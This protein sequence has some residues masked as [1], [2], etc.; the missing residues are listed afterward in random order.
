MF[1]SRDITIN[2]LVLS[3]CESPTILT[4]LLTL[5]LVMVTMPP[6]PLAAERHHSAPDTPAPIHYTAF[7]VSSEVAVVPTIRSGLD[8]KTIMEPLKDA[9]LPSQV[10]FLL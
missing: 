8:R 3:D 10:Y 4:A 6:L 9:R 5:L 2:R 7:R 1:L